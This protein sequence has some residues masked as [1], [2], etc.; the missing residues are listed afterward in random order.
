MLPFE[1]Q[2]QSVSVPGFQ[3]SDILDKCLT[4][5]ILLFAKLK[6]LFTRVKYTKLSSIYKKLQPRA[7]LSG[8][9]NVN[10]RSPER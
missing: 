5:F 9:H 2:G 10:F 8:R 7:I 1:I 3:N 6:Y 4:V